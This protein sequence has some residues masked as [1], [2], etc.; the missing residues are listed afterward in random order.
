MI[1]TIK[2]LFWVSRPVSWPNTAYPFAAGY[3]VLGGQ[4]DLALILGTLF[5]LFPYNL[6]MYGVNDVFD[7]ESDILNPRKG[8][9]EGMKE[10]KAFHPAIMKAVAIVNVPFIIY[11]LSIGSAGAKIV[12]AGLVFFVLAYSL[13]Y[14]RFKEIPLLDSITSSIHFV[15][16]LVFALALLGFPGG[17]WPFVA[18][19]FLWGMA[20]HAFGAVQ[21]IIPD[22]KGGLHSVATVIGA[23]ATVCGAMI[24]YLAA[25]ILVGQVGG[26]S[27]LVA[28]A[29]LL[30]IANIWPYRSVTDEAS[31][32]TNKAW[33]RFIRL[34][35][36]VGFVVTIALILHA[37]T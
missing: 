2:K 22:R 18:A 5:F 6:M 30:Y 31:G 37:I 1:A 28:A 29:G 10:E 32:S 26:W 27:L 33:K 14:L 19:F 35:Y 13:K 36:F 21:D 17:A 7:Y 12:F 8:G 34:N 23:R 9:V 15:G 3:L 4:V 16:P 25:A 11:F 24:L 20:S